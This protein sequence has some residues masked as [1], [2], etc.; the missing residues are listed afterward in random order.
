[1]GVGGLTS[2]RTSSFPNLPGYIFVETMFS[3][4]LKIGGQNMITEKY[5]RKIWILLAKIFSSVVSDSS[6]LALL[7][8]WQI[9]LLS[10]RIGRPIQLYPLVHSPAPPPQAPQAPPTRPPPGTSA[11]DARL[12]MSIAATSKQCC[13]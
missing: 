12:F 7:V 3:L 11:A 5:T 9:D 2:S 10:A 4:V 13:F 6:Y 1:M 8:R